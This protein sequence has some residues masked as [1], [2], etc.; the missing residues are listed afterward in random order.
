MNNNLIHIKGKILHK[1][2]TPKGNNVLLRIGTGNNIVLCFITDPTLKKYTEAFDTGDY[3]NLIGNIQSSRR[4]DSN[5]NRTADTQVVFVES[6]TPPDY[7]DN[8]YY[9]HFRICG[10]IVRVQELKCCLK[11][12]VRTNNNGRLS[13]VPVVIYHPANHI[14]AF[15]NGDY[16]Q[17][18]GSVQ[19]VKKYDIRTGK[20]NYYQN[21]VAEKMW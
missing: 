2:V 11:I 21:Y 9:N 10:K 17:A 14:K 15:N 3:I 5:Q 7:T 12:T 18:E 4:F 13:F 1:Y 16:I 20:Y 8:S 19:S 6:I